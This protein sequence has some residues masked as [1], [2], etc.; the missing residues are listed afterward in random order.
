MRPNNSES[1][2]D[3]LPL[4]L[5]VPSSQ[6]AKVLPSDPVAFL[7]P[8]GL[9]ATPHHGALAIP[10]TC[11]HTIACPER[12]PCA[13][14][15][16]NPHAI[17]TATPATTRAHPTLRPARRHIPP[18]I[19]PYAPEC[20]KH[21]DIKAIAQGP[22]SHVFVVCS[23]ALHATVSARDGKQQLVHKVEVFVAMRP[24]SMA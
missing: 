11:A 21:A 12:N 17:L 15:T 8:W 3:W 24:K 20:G 9:H 10:A 1:E 23:A 22:S 16:H 5:T 19:Q 7:D 13:Q 6:I 2:T 18:Q 4:C 14:H